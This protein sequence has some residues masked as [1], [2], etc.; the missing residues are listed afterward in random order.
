MGEEGRETT[1]NADTTFYRLPPP[2]LLLLF[3]LRFP[4]N[5]MG[6]YSKIY[7]LSPPEGET[8]DTGKCRSGLINFRGTACFL[9][10]LFLGSNGGDFNAPKSFFVAPSSSPFFSHFPNKIIFLS[11]PFQS[12]SKLRQKA[13]LPFPSSILW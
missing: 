4:I 6:K 7:G 11:S 2:H 1:A 8:R 5:L 12:D 9:K 13:L 3:P 10:N